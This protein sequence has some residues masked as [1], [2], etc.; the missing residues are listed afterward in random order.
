MINLIRFLFYLV[1]IQLICSV[2]LVECNLASLQPVMVRGRLPMQ[3]PGGS[4]MSASGQPMAGLSMPQFKAPQFG[5][6]PSQ[7]ANEALSGLKVNFDKLSSKNK[8]LE[9]PI[10]KEVL[11]SNVEGEHVPY[12]FLEEYGDWLSKEE[13][14]E[15]DEN[16]S[17]NI[18]GSEHVL[19]TT[20]CDSKGQM[21]TVGDQGVC[22]CVFQ[23]SAAG[24]DQE[25][26]A[27]IHD[28]Q[29]HQ[30]GSVECGF[31]CGTK[32]MKPLPSLFNKGCVCGKPEKDLWSEMS[33]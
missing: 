25:T 29:K 14:D 4:G 19:C 8:P 32:M 18:L 5:G 21:A 3:R 26:K 30:F 1:E 17:C 15:Y 23:M 27:R 12:D 2:I 13:R 28:C 24:L 31:C 7:W 20:C 6:N 11:G 22:S 10:Q 16:G 33:Q 9:K